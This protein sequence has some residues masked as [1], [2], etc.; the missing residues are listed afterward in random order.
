MLW[1]DLL[2]LSISCLHSFN[3]FFCQGFNWS[4]LLTFDPALVGARV[5]TSADRP[6]QPIDITS[7]LQR[8][9]ELLNIPI[10]DL[11]KDCAEVK[12][13]LDELKPL[14]PEPLHVR[15]WPAG[16]LPFFRAEVETVRR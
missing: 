13:I 12:E 1:L 11:V 8:V 2:I 7:R 15:L 5:T 10:D 3:P 9:K 4:A 16:Y 6:P 14:L